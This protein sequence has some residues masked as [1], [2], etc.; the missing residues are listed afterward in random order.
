MIEE[1]GVRYKASL[2]RARSQIRMGIR[3]NQQRLVLKISGFCNGR[4]RRKGKEGSEKKNVEKR[5][6]MTGEKKRNR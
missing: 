3:R 4:R 1:G 5:A 6:N 2:G